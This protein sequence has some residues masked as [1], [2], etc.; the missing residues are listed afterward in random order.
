MDI[1]PRIIIQQ[2]IKGYEEMMDISTTASPFLYLYYLLP[3]FIVVIFFKSPQGKGILGEFVVNVAA[4]LLLDKDRYH[5]I[6]NVT[7]PTE[8]GTTQIDHIIVSEYGIFVIESKNMKGWIFGDERQSH[9]TQKIYRY[10]HKFQNPLRQNYKH[11]KTIQHILDIEEEKIFSV[12]VFVGDCTF[13]TEMPENVRYGI[14]YIDYI[15]SKTDKLFSAREV[16]RFVSLIESSRLARSL[17]TR[18]RHINNVKR[19][20]DEKERANLC[21]KCGAQLLLRTAKKGANAGKKFYGCS[22]FPRCRYSAPVPSDDTT[23]QNLE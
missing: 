1:Y 17:N 21:P 20:L 10:S 6:K 16:E 5:L 2:I 3:I 12:V 7:I 9:W 13:K 18:L 22:N 15:K 19:I 4:K 23:E 11:V 14:G 8:D